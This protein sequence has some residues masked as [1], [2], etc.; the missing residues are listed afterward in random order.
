MFKPEGVYFAM[1]TPF[2][3]GKVNEKVLRQLVEFDV[4]QGVHGLFPVSTS[5]EFIQMDFAEKVRMMEIVADQAAGRVAVTPGVTAPNPRECIALAKEAKRIG[6]NAV[7]VSPPYYIPLTQGMVQAHVE[8]VARAVDMP[9][10]LYNIPA[11]TS[12][13]SLGTL[14][15]LC[16]LPNVVAMK[17]STGSMQDATHIVDT[18]RLAGRADTFSFFTGREDAVVP[19]LALGAKGCVTAASGIVPE[20]MV[21]IWDNYKKGNYDKAKELQYSVLEMIRIWSELPLPV[22]LKTALA[23][24]GF[25]MGEP[26]QPLSAPEMAQIPNVRSRL[27]KILRGLLGDNYKVDVE[28]LTK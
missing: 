12:P 24:R 1:V 22:G 21:G 27:E 13:I 17:D 11:F 2:K 18:I 4:Q 16:A 25:D 10:I 6:C 26:V 3:N 20:T 8:A 19:A 15:K 5:G 28:Y 14:E 23:V 9:V 7:V